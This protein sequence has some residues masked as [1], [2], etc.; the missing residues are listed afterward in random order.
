MPIIAG[1]R[2]AAAAPELAFLEIDAVKIRGKERPERIFALLG[3]ENVARSER[4]ARATPSAR[5]SAGGDRGGRR[6]GGS[7]RAR[8]LPERL[9]AT[10]CHSSTR[11]MSGA[12]EQTSPASVTG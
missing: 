10:R 2:T 8:G 4:F 6:C 1:E 3:D 12:I 9:A 5:Q 11:N 7:C